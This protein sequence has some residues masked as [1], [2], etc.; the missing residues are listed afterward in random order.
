MAWWSRG[1][2]RQR[3][4]I[5]L[6]GIL[7]L[8]AAGLRAQS[9]PSHDSVLLSVY[10]QYLMAIETHDFDKLQALTADGTGKQQL[11]KLKEGMDHFMLSTPTETVCPI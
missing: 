1:A 8:L 10:G 11:A 7:V 9:Q 6:V 5:A 4:S 3:S 2:G